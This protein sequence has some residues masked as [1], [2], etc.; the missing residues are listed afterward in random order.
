[1]TMD[2]DAQAEESALHVFRRIGLVEP[3]RIPTVAKVRVCERIETEANGSDG[4]GHASL[5]DRYAALTTELPLLGG[6]AMSRNADGTTRLVGGLR[7]AAPWMGGAIDRVA[8]QIDLALW[9]GR[10]WLALRPLLLVGGPGTGKSHFAKLLAVKSGCG[11]LQLGMGGETDNRALAGTARGW[12]SAQPALPLVAMTQCRTANP[13]MLLDEIEKVSSDR[14]SGNV[15]ETLLSMTEPTTAGDWYDRCLLAPADLRHVVWIATANETTSIPPVLLSRFDV[16]QVESPGIADLPG[17]IA[18]LR[19]GLAERWDVPVDMLP[20]L[21]VEVERL[22]ARHF[23]RTRSI[24][25]LRRG[26]EV[27]LS[28]AVRTSPRREH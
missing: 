6:D 28:H 27:A 1:M 19:S 15:H 3:Y 16:V 18:G 4:F 13:V 7:A 17:L 2:V 5:G 10:P 11:F 23:A 20:A 12:L 8:E 21:P 22:L 9:A 24:R 25:A 26:V 14:R